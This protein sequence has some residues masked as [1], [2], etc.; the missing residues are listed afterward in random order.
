LV[1]ALGLHWE[2][3]RMEGKTRRSNPRLSRARLE[4]NQAKEGKI[5]TATMGS[6]RKTEHGTTASAVREEK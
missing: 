4:T 3:E 2:K 5:V 1:G 6:K